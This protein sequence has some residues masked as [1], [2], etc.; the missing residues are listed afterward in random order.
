MEG[1]D[2]WAQ[3]AQRAPDKNP[4]HMIIKMAKIKERIL[5]VGREKQRMMSKVTPMRLSADFSGGQR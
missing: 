2:V 1:K 4:R 3:E 5:K